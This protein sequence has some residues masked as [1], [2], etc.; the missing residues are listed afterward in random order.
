VLRQTLAEK[1]FFS[2]EAC[3]A[4]QWATVNGGLNAG[5]ISA[6]QAARYIKNNS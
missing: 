1:L 5:K 6:N 4:T 3:H 2:G